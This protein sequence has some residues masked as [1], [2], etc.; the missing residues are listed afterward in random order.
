VNDA[1]QSTG[2]AIRACLVVASAFLVSS[3]ALLQPHRPPKKLGPTDPILL[4]CAYV[5]GIDPAK[6]QPPKDDKRDGNSQADTIAAILTALAEDDTADSPGG[7]NKTQVSLAT[8]GGILRAEG[9]RQAYF[10]AVQWHSGWRNTTTFLTIPLAG[11]A[12]REGLDPNP[13]NAKIADFGVATVILYGWSTALTSA[14]RQ[15]VYINGMQAMSCAMLEAQPLLV[16]V[17]QLQTLAEKQKRVGTA[18]KALYLALKDANRADLKRPENQVYVVAFGEAKNAAA[19][20]DEYAVELALAAG[21]L[22]PLVERISEQVN[23]N[24]IDTETSPQSMLA[25]LQGFGTQTRAFTK[26]A[27]PGTATAGTETASA[28]SGEDDPTKSRGDPAQQK[29]DKAHAELLEAT[30]SLNAS[31]TRIVTVSS[32]TTKLQACK[33]DA[34]SNKFSVTP[35]DAVITLKEGATAEFKVVNEVSVPVAELVGSNTDKVT[36][37]ET[38]VRDGAFVIS[39]KG[40][41]VTGTEGPTLVITD[42]TGQQEKR[43]QIN[44]VGESQP[45]PPPPEVDPSTPLS[46][47]ER[48]VLVNSALGTEV[49]GD[50]PA[51][52]KNALAYVQCVMGLT[53]DDIDGKMGATTRGRIKAFRKSPAV[54]HVNVVD[55]S[56]I[57]DVKKVRDATQPSCKTAI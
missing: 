30:D 52:A 16:G 12:V 36:R 18:I 44:V 28:E 41:K 33:A 46:D 9:Y 35:G 29:I 13:S 34:V 19:R 6:L 7:V 51:T 3:C 20:V 39:V 15:K 56:L 10:S 50:D 23:R 42:G 57:E 1:V 31:L 40:E 14:P 5:T 43:I 17:R 53:G 48:T 4:S 8:C 21:N 2:R 49:S 24:I 32:V 27:L 54:M 47:A 45:P 22:T 11:L 37:A 38:I 55:S 26:A 25:L